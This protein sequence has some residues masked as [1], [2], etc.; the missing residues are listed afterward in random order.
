MEVLYGN[1]NAPT[2][3][4]I[5]EKECIWNQIVRQVFIVL[6]KDNSAL[7]ADELEIDLKELIYDR[8]Q[9]EDKLRFYFENKW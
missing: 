5:I 1:E 2:R 8:N 3:F 9:G 7:D 4:V 6:R